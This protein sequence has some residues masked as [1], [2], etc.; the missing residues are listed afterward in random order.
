M[1]ENLNLDAR[2]EYLLKKLLHLEWDMK[3]KQIN[4]ARKMELDNYKKE[5]ETIEAQLSG[6]NSGKTL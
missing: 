1:E 2:K 5:L 4:F 6:G 3:L